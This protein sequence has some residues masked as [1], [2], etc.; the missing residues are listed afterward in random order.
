MKRTVLSIFLAIGA[1]LFPEI[2]FA[3]AAVVEYLVAKPLSEVVQA[4]AQPVQSGPLRVP[5]ITWGG[6]VSTIYTQTAKAFE[7]E[8]FKNVELF[9]ENDFKKQVEGALSGKTPFLRGTLG[10]IN[11]AAP[12]FEREGTP[13]VVIFQL[14]WSSGGDTITVRQNI[15]TPSDLSGKTIAL[16]LYGPHM[17]Y[18]A[19]IVS[20]A[21]AQNVKFKWLKELTL[22]TYDTKGKVVDPVSAF[23]NDPTID[24]VMAISPDAAAMTTVTA[25]G[26]CGEGCVKGAKVLLSTK[27]ASRVI[28]DVYAVRKDYFDAHPADVQRFVH[29]LMRGQEQFQDLYQHKAERQAEFRQLLTKSA[30][31]LMGAPQATSDVEG[32]LGDCEF[33]GFSGNVQFFTGQNT[34]RSFDVLNDEINSAFV[35]TSL[36][37]GPTKLVNANFDYTEL[38]K[39]LKNVGNVPV[40]A[41]FDSKK[42]QASVEKQIAAEPT[43]WA[44]KGTLFEVEIN[45]EPNQSDFPA[46]KYAKDFEKAVKIS[47]TYGGS[48]VVIEGH[49]D[50]LGV[51]K[52]RQEG[53]PQVEVTQ[54]EQQAKNLSFQ[55]AQ[56]IRASFL[57]YEKSKGRTLD[58]SQF[59]AVGLG[60]STP[61]YN[62][63]RTKDEWAANRRGVFRIKQVEAESEEFSP[64]Q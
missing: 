31:L 28:G 54:M 8:G 53:K 2:S 32:M 41:K 18:V 47:Q 62:P 9:L 58:E 63:P 13:L 11:E 44:E 24:A 27:T 56:A 19:N 61:K 55:R 5:V 51:L 30:D 35:R 52:A 34:L 3:N 7:Q 16:Q 4:K 21:N 48:L 49:S 20:S 1:I 22:P 25:D 29:A 12:V 23:R 39:G 64:L 50:P 17:D 40:K 37:A 10:M 46:A 26:T 14:T 15:K 57:E 60:V 36:L 59:I 33:V 38:A 43:E 42:A 6:D 45:F